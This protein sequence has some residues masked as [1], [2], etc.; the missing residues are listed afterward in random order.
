MVVGTHDQEI[1]ADV[2]DMRKQ[3]VGNAGEFR[4]CKILRIDVMARAL[5]Q[6]QRRRVGL[7]QLALARAKP[8]WILDE[9]LTALDREAAELVRG[10]VEEHLRRGGS[11]VLTSHQDVDFGTAS[12]TRLRL[13]A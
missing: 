3:S 10:H 9:P 11:I 2:G 6:G 8:L 13:D 4:Q 5:S 7:A 1:R 12:V